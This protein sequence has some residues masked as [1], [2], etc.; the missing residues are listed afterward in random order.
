VEIA[1]EEYKYQD[2]MNVAT[3]EINHL[4]AIRGKQK[5]FISTLPDDKYAEFN[6]GLIKELV[7]GLS[8]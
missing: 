5:K 3:L 7:I 2:E 8:W 4:Y 6:E 1:K